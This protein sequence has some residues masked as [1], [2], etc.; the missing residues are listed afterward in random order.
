MQRET[1]APLLYVMPYDTID[2]AIAMHN[3]VPQGLSSAIF[4]SDVREAE[5]FLSPSGSGYAGRPG[6]QSC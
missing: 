1:F 3:D 2:E 5:I 4:T 6:I